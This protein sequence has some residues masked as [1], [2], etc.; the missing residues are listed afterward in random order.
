MSKVSL[1]IDGIEIR[2]GEGEKLLWAALDA[3]IY[4]PSL[5]AIRGVNPPRAGCRLCFVQIEGQP[6][7]VTACTEPVADGM[8]VYTNTPRVN[9]LR[10]TA[11]EL[12]MSNHP[13]ECAKCPKNRDCELQRIA[14]HLGLKLRQKRFR[15]IPRSLPVDS[16]HPL[17]TYDPNQCVLCGK[18]V[19][20]CTENGKGVLNFAFRGVDM[21]VSTFDNIPLTESNCDGCLECVAVCPVAA[22]VL[23]STG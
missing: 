14:S 9:R 5:C 16:S 10:R 12:L 8:V 15:S 11:F 22:L 6:R 17:F 1:T 4:I 23:K 2:A 19:W 7:P 13:V 21:V 18:C 3:G 20:V